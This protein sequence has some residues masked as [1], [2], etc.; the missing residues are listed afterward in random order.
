MAQEIQYNE[1]TICGAN[2]GRCGNTFG[3]VGKDY[4]HCENCRDTLRD[5]VLTIHAHL[6]RTDEEIQRTAALLEHVEV[7]V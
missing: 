4:H 1:C 6:R 2:N 5:G 3:R 7:T